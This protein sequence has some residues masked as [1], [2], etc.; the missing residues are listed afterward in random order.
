MEVVQ[1][2]Q[3]AQSRPHGHIQKMME[4][5]IE[6]FIRSSHFGHTHYSDV[7]TIQIPTEHQLRSHLEMAMEIDRMF[8][9]ER[10]REIDRGPNG[11][12]VLLIL[13]VL[14]TPYYT[15]KQFFEKIILNLKL[16]FLCLY[17]KESAKIIHCTNKPF[18]N[19]YQDIRTG[20]HM[21]IL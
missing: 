15:R 14:A 8:T 19:L 5:E 1:I 11:R 16:C 17:I 18:L 13:A 9:R 12:T 10:E 6:L 2:E 7:Y 4:M 21:R 20:F 3:T